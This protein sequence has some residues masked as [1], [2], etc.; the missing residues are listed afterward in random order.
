ML[1]ER[2]LI[3]QK[4]R[5]LAK[6]FE[7]F[8]EK[9]LTP[10]SR[11]VDPAELR[12]YVDIKE[13]AGNLIVTAFRRGYLPELPGLAELVDWLETPP[14]AQGNAICVPCG[15]N[16]F[17]SF[18]GNHTIPVL[19]TGRGVV[20]QAGVK[21]C[22]GVLPSAFPEILPGVEAA[23]LQAG[24]PEWQ[25]NEEHHAMVCNWLADGVEASKSP[26]P[27]NDPEEPVT[28]ST[29]A[30]RFGLTPK[31]ADRLRKSLAKWRSPANCTEWTE[32]QD[33]KPRKSPYIYRLGSIQH[34]IDSAK[35]AD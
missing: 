6:S 23:K 14:P 34:L 10:T 30:K 20:V 26:P 33:R 16:V 13:E 7:R 17:I 32:A 31:Q 18:C 8:A 21:T 28:P 25:A 29:I 24:Y 2:S 11:G 12:R 22:G 35:S 5:S 3:A 27:Y 15:A 1:N 19:N 9:G 4:F